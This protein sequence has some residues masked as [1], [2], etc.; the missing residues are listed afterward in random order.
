MMQKTQHTIKIIA[1][2]G[3]TTRFPENTLEAFVA[4]LSGGADGIEL[5]VHM[6]ADGELIVHHDYYLGNP[7]NGHG[8]IP[9][10][11]ANTVH[12][13]TIKNTYRLPTLD[14]VFAKFG[15]LL[16]YELEI[17]SYTQDA[18]DKI[19]A[20]VHR[21]ALADY[22]EFT[23]PHPYVL[24]Q[25]KQTDSRLIAG[26]FA[27]PQPGWMDDTLYRSICIAHTKMAALNILH[28]PSLLVT[29]EFV[30]DAHAAGL[31][32]HAADCNDIEDLLRV[33]GLSVDQLSTNR[34][35]EAITAV[36]NRA[37]PR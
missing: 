13:A 25:L 36:R 26:Y 35:A 22:I 31:G 5:D 17:K 14:E 7:D 30:D 33:A 2:R 15:N 9:N 1:H 18:L 21:Y 4:A 19:L 29:E 12:K 6:T 16:H 37:F 28:V 3:D 27:P 34:L 8:I 32:I 10:I 20:T 11:T 23:S 24:T